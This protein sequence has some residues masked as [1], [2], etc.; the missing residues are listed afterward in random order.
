MVTQGKLVSII[1]VVTNVVTGVIMAMLIWAFIIP[2]LFPRMAGPIAENFLVTFTF[3][4][5]SIMRGYLW[6]RFFATGL[7]TTLVNWI[8]RVRRGEN[9]KVGGD[10]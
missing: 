2:E 4:T 7:H 9:G 5:F 3:T 10:T 6:R 1:E 8:G